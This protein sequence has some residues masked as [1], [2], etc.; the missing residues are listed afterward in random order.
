VQQ[1]A[2]VESLAQREPPPAPDYGFD[3]A[4]NARLLAE[5]FGTA[6]PH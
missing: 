2:Y 6:L 5:G 4:E 3:D 1:A